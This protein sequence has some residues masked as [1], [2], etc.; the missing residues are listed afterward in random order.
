M[1]KRILLI[2]ILAFGFLIA[3]TS[4]SD[5]IDNI[6]ISSLASGDMIQYDG[7]NWVNTSA[8]SS[9][10]ITM[11]DEGWIGLGAAKGRLV[12]NDEATDLLQFKDCAVD[13]DG[14]F[15][16][17][18]LTSDGLTSGRVVLAGTAG[19]LEDSANMLFDGT[20]LTMGG[21]VILAATKKI[22]LAADTYF[23][24]SAADVLDGYVGGVKF[25]WTEDTDITFSVDA[26]NFWKADVTNDD[27]DLLAGLNIGSL[28]GATD[29]YQTL[30]DMS[31]TSSPTSGD[32]EGFAIKV[33][34]TTIFSVM[35]DADGSGGI[36]GERVV[37]DGGHINSITTIAASTYDLLVSDYILN[38]TYTGTGA[39]TSLTLP[40]AQ[41]VAGR[42]I[43]IKDA[44]G[45]AGTN[46]ITVDTEGAETIDGGATAVI[47]SNYSSI[48]LYSDGS[49]WFIY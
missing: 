33:D 26:V 29:T 30:I 38:V 49:N 10:S 7:T 6:S 23:I 1:K 27:F 3:D 28:T 48:N 8:F 40:T 12:F 41:T 17:S 20:D 44:G 16:A 2:L 36:T 15:S 31:V 42:T 19:I 32:D 4:F 14:A 39:V 47:S 43:I 22:Y 5:F 46:N 24:E 35:A 21:D 11:D 45:L 9:S 18:N 13:V 25:T 37:I 34:G